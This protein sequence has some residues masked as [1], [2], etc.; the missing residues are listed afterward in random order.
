MPKFTMLIGMP[1]TG[2]TTRRRELLAK[3]TTAEQINTFV[4]A[5]DDKV[6]ELMS[7]SKD[8]YSMVVRKHGD[9]LVSRG[10]YELA[11][12]IEAGKDVIVDAD[13]ITRT[14]RRK[15]FEML[16]RE[17]LAYHYEVDGVWLVYPDGTMW[18]DVQER[19]NRS[20]KQTDYD[21]WIGKGLNVAEPQMS[22]G[23]DTLN[24]EIVEL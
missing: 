18:P 11:L 22:E 7:M 1:G 21:T 3:M 9:S 14:A 16:D 12:A 24:C 2:K 6:Y 19:V 23:F 4:L 5:L 8:S 13:N 20:E 15:L 17:D 10:F